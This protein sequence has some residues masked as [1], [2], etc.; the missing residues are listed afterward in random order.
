MAVQHDLPHYYRQR[1][2][3]Q[4]LVPSYQSSEILTPQQ[5][6]QRL[7]V[8]PGRYEEYLSKLSTPAR[9]PWG[10]EREY[11]G[12][13]PVCLPNNHRPKAEPP[14]QEAKGHKHYGYGGDPWPRGLPIEQYYDITQLRKSAV[15][16]SDDLY[17]KPPDVSIN[18]KQISTGFPAE[19]PYQSHISKFAM[20]PS[21]SPPEEPDCTF[22]P[23]HPESAS[24]GYE[25]IVLRKTSGSPYRHEIILEPQRPLTWPGQDGYF[26][27]PKSNQGH[28]QIY[29]PV[30][31]KTVAPN[32]FCKSPEEPLSEKT[33]NLQRS[34]IKS[35]WITS[36]SRSF[37]D[38]GEMNR[39]D[40]SR[41]LDPCST[42]QLG[43]SVEMN[44]QLEPL[45]GRAVCFQAS[46][47][48]TDTT[49]KLLN[50]PPQGRNLQ[51]GISPDCGIPFHS[52]HHTP[53]GCDTS[54][55]YCSDRFCCPEEHK[56]HSTRKCQFREPELRKITDTDKT[57]A[58]YSRQ[59]V[60]VPVLQDSE[61]KPIYDKEFH[62]SQAENAYCN[63]RKSFADNVAYGITGESLN[64]W[65][66][67]QRESQAPVP[68]ELC[69]KK[70][71]QGPNLL[72]LQSSFSRTKAYRDFHQNFSDKTMDLRDNL[73]SG[74]KHKFFGFNSFY[75]HN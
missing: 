39:L 13:G 50:F 35:Q 70:E 41:S 19:H 40:P 6:P 63:L 12:I 28:T 7:T 67:D 48:P 30:P 10:R 15:R 60:Q 16:A 31:P 20:F 11:G 44:L 65:R 5:I 57:D 75:F 23:L 46:N 3:A 45:E 71:E 55:D 37:P 49:K 8:S 9:L 29:Y 51:T 26:H 24:H 42:R 14:P 69:D 2:G 25:T 38:Y 73:N 74:K 52:K 58:L 68:G 32:Y 47:N 18:I 66:N 27:F 64:G 61:I 1:E 72:E 17:P 4:W 22:S 56:A 21:Y 33:V 34:L 59:L 36:Y 43:G 54:P 53:P 62:P